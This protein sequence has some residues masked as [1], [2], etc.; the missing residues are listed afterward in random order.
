MFKR[1]L[2]ILLISSLLIS[3]VLAPSMLAQSTTEKDAKQTAKLKARLAK[4][5]TGKKTRIEVRLPDSSKQTG[6]LSQVNDESFVLTDP[7]TGQNTEFKYA[8]ISD[9]KN[10]GIPAWAKVA[11][12][13]GAVLGAILIFKAAC[14]NPDFGCK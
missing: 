13:G 12:V 3:T 11:I 6:Y 1:N 5:N 14:G 8:N 10:R 7:K 2:S 9:A 4:L